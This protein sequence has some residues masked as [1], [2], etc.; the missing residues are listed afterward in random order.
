MVKDV[1]RVQMREGGRRHGRRYVRLHLL[2]QTPVRLLEDLYV[3][4]HRIELLQEI[5][6]LLLERAEL[7]VLLMKKVVLPCHGLRRLGHW[8]CHHHVWR[9][10]WRNGWYCYLPKHWLT[11]RRS[12]KCRRR[13]R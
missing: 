1:A 13:V 7:Y 6:M 12:E 9:P 11:H 5:L 3:H 10:V 8:R 4:A 2:G